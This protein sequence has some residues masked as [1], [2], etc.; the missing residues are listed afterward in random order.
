MT[1]DIVTRLRS[2]YQGQLPICLEAAD[3]IER[4]REELDALVSHQSLSSQPFI[5]QNHQA[6]LH[7]RGELE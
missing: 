5:H 1:N 7:T 3:E 2:K 4:L 6:S